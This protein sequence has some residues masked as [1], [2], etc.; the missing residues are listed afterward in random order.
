M[1]IAE[2]VRKI[3]K[4]MVLP[5]LGQIHGEY[6]EIKSILEITNKR[7]DDM[8]LQLVEQSKRIDETNKRIDE[9]NK[10]IDETN[11]KMDSLHSD[12]IQR[13]DKTNNKV[14]SIH[15]DL[16][17][18]IDETRAE[19]RGEIGKLNQQV[20]EIILSVARLH[21]VTV[22]REEHQELKEQVKKIAQQVGL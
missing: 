19:L 18:R 12:L 22:S 7:L 14:D 4:E 16:I 6:R 8:N 10:R 2:A 11:N 21:Q 17:H 5:E 13:N 20:N 3:I 15:S 1:E 9:T